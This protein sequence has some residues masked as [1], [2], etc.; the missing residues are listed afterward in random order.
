MSKRHPLFTLCRND[1]SMIFRDLNDRGV[2]RKQDTPSPQALLEN[3]RV[4]IQKWEKAEIDGWHIHNDKVI[5]DFAHLRVH[6][7]RGCL[8]HIPPGG[9]TNRNENLHR[10]LNPFF[11]RCRMGIPLA[12]AL[13][14]ALFHRHKQ[15]LS[16][17]DTC[18]S[19]LSAR[20]QVV[21]KPSQC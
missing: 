17:T 11:S 9:G 21:S 19:I 4:F 8:S 6:I 5:A 16:N 10:T 18:Y 1:V 20:T 14:S 12:L 13:L 3:V 2:E 15:K 7:T